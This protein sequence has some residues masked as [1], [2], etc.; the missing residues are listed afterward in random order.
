MKVVIT[1][2]FNTEYLSVFAKYFK[3]LD[4]V[5][6]LRNKRHKM[7][8]LHIPF[9]KFKNNV[10]L[11]SIRWVLVENKDWTLIPLFVFFKKDKRYWED[12]RWDLD[13]KFIKQEFQFA[14]KDI[15]NEKY[16]IF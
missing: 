13:K 15:K 12:L 11:I 1:D 3:K 10:N 16:E 9:L 6:E 4:F 8:V 7:I 5:N 2:R 14:M